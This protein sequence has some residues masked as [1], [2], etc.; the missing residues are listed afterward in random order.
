MKT[1][2]NFN[3]FLLVSLLILITSCQNEPIQSADLMPENVLPSNAP[4]VGMIRSATANDV[5]ND[6]DVD[7]SSCFS[8][9]FPFT[10]LV[11]DVAM[12]FE[13][14]YDL[15]GLSNLFEAVEVVFEFPLTIIFDD[16]SEIVVLNEDE[17]EAYL[18]A[19]YDDIDDS[20]DEFED[21][22]CVNFVYPLTVLAYD[23][24]G[25]F[26]DSTVVNNDQ[27]LYELFEAY[28]GASDDQFVYLALE[29]PVSLLFADGTQITVYND[30]ELEEAFINAETCFDDSDDND[31]FDY[32]MCDPEAL[33]TQ[34]E[35][36]DCLY[37][38]EGPQTTLGWYLDF[39]ENGVL[40]LD[41][42]SIDTG[43]IITTT[44]D[45]FVDANGM[46]VMTI[47]SLPT[48]FSAY[49]GDWLFLTCD[50]EFTVIQSISDP[51]M[52]LFLI[53]ECD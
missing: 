25:L 37:F 16:Y 50:S 49:S 34:L 43:L 44:Y 10:L 41:A 9:A 15:E 20:D 46:S 13:N 31:G 29:F 12:T 2:R 8:I 22:S 14:E 21:Y 27:A 33:L 11:N 51:A 6:D 3:S 18:D 28:E 52:V 40:V 45:I 5:S 30:Q 35:E 32:W 4:L 19:C 36:E 47:G 17:F 23:I 39:Y 53:A 48:E 24:N 1:V 26:I 7:G 38:V 42:N